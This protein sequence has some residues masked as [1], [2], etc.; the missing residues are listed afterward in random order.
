MRN[1][2]IYVYLKPAASIAHAYYVTSTLCTATLSALL[3]VRE[4]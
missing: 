3:V 2:D 1:H 4:E